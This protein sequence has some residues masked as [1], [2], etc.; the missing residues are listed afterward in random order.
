MCD[1]MIGHCFIVSSMVAILKPIKMYL[2]IARKF[3]PLWS[4]SEHFLNCS[5]IKYAWN[6]HTERTLRPWLKYNSI[7]M[8]SGHFSPKQTVKI[9]THA[10]LCN[11]CR[12]WCLTFISEK[13]STLPFKISFVL[14]LHK[15]LCELDCSVIFPNWMTY[16]K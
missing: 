7:L 6:F 16:I 11:Q 13:I 9:S 2:N 3:I 1:R 12:N 4:T 14:H 8:A 5:H 10:T 15:V